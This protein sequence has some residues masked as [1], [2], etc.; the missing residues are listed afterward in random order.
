MDMHKCFYHT[1]LKKKEKRINDCPDI[2]YAKNRHRSLPVQAKY[3][4]QG[5][6]SKLFLSRLFQSDLSS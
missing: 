3:L 2:L 5:S 1:E 4:F 6:W